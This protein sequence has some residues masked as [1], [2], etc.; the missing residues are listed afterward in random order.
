MPS[1]TF[2]PLSASSFQPLASIS[3]PLVSSN[4]LFDHCKGERDYRERTRITFPGGWNHE[5]DDIFQ[6]Y[7]SQPHRRFQAIEYCKEKSGVQHEFIRVLLQNDQGDREGSFCRIE[8]VADIE[9]RI[10]AIRNQGTTA[11]DFIQTID[12]GLPPD[13]EHTELSIVDDTN[14]ELLAQITFP[15]MFDLVDVLAICFGMH[16]HPQAKNYTLQQFNCYF[17]SWT[18]ILCLARRAADWNAVVRNHTEALCQDVLRHLG[19]L[20]SSRNFTVWSIMF[21]LHNDQTDTSDLHQSPPRIT[22]RILSEI[23]AEAFMNAVQEM[24]TPLLWY[25][26]HPAKLQESLG[27]SLD[28][29]A[30]ETSGSWLESIFV[31]SG[32]SQK[33]PFTYLGVFQSELSRICSVTWVNRAILEIGR[34]EIQEHKKYHMQSAKHDPTA[35]RMKHKLVALGKV[36][37]EHVIPAPIKMPAYTALLFVDAYEHEISTH[38]QVRTQRYFRRPFAFVKTVLNGPKTLCTFFKWYKEETRGTYHYSLAERFQ[39]TSRNAT[40]RPTDIDALHLGIRVLSESINI[41]STRHRETSISDLRKMCADTMEYFC[42]TQFEGRHT[43]SRLWTLSFRD[44]LGKVI[45]Q[46]ILSII[47]GQSSEAPYFGWVCRTSRSYEFSKL[48]DG[49]LGSQTH[50][51]W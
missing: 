29:I 10:E 21:G 45:A 23:T 40:P 20:H 13:P 31:N 47:E 6:W 51:I 43:M 48:N 46:S 3:P 8:R 35:P 27:K 11:F 2:P 39:L 18:I 34:Q 41:Y 44:D 15:R 33:I 5:D 1:S 50:G 7:H 37:L 42:R 49:L 16:K 22:E 19:S 14:V 9:H 36:A 38:P 24:L 17:F 4:R 30:R 25:N 32:K 26:Q 28:A 12:P